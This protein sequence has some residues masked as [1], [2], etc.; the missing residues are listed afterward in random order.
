MARPRVAIVGSVEQ[1]RKLDPPLRQ[2]EEAK[3][4]AEQLGREL[5]EAGWDLTVYSAD[6][7]FVEAD[8]V[9]GYVGSGKAVAASIQL[10]APRGKGG[11]FDEMTGQADL[12]DVR[13]DSSRDWEVSFYRSLPQCDGILLIGGGRSTLVTGLIALTMCIPTVAVATFGGNAQKV[14]ES[15]D[16]ER[17]DATEEDVA[18]MANDW[19]ESSAKRLVQSLD[20]QRKAR[21]LRQ[22]KDIR[23]QRAR[24]RRALTSLVFSAVLLLAAIGTIVLAWGWR[25][26]TAGSVFALI[27]VPV[28]AAAAGALIRTSLDAGQEWTRAAILGGAAGLI[29]GLLFVASQLIGAPN[30]LEASATQGVRRLLFFVL[31][32]GFIAGLTFDA[33][34]SRLRSADVSQVDTLDKLTKV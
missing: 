25:P 19:R 29:A 26:G 17:N 11:S 34:Y 1:T 23:Q 14:W 32:I 6:P 5:A 8:V 7:D 27:V 28:L 21:Q 10:R 9:H 13:S 12:F 2:P 18:A 16:K 22:Q 20:A 15:L 31:P 4:A 33:V 30:V 24:S 3:R